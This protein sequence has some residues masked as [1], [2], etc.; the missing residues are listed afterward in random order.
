[1]TASSQVPKKT[2]EL[3]PGIDHVLF[4]DPERE[5]KVDKAFL[6]YRIFRGITNTTLVYL[7]DPRNPGYK[8]VCRTNNN[9]NW[10]VVPRPVLGP[11][12]GV[13]SFRAVHGVDL[14]Q[15]GMAV[16]SA[17]LQ[18]GRQ[19]EVRGTWTVTSNGNGQHTYELQQ[20]RA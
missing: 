9:T 14:D 17:V 4:P 13:Q 8:L 11:Q 3:V 12:R 18:D 19:I 1:M 5:E 16:V 7:A 10:V 20:K 2:K 15:S 6:V